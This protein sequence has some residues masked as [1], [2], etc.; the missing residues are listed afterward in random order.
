[1]RNSLSDSL[2]SLALKLLR[3]GAKPTAELPLP[4]SYIASGIG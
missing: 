1:M 4:P 2:H 3:L